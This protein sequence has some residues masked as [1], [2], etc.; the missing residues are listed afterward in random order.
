MKLKNDEAQLDASS[1]QYK[2]EIEIGFPN[3]AHAE[4]TMK[5]L[6]V[7]KEISGDKVAKIFASKENILHVKFEATEAKLLRVSVSS[8]YDML[9]VALK[10]FNEFGN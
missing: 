3:A 2:C 8:F 1:R 6:S 7:D 10:C 9:E 4:M 5:V